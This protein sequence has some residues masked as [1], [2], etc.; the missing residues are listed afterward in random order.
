MIEIIH[1]LKFLLQKFRNKVARDVWV[2]LGYY[3]NANT[4]K[5]IGRLIVS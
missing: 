3:K 1:T 4:F 5:N 2:N